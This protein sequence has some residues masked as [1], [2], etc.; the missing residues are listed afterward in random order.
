MHMVRRHR[1]F[2]ISYM[3]GRKRNIVA[4]YDRHILHVL[5]EVGKQGI[6]VNMLSKHVYNLSSTLFETPDYEEVYRYV[7]LFVRSHAKNS[8]SLL[9][10]TGEW[11]VYRLNEKSAEY[12]QAKLQFSEGEDAAEAMEHADDHRS[13]EDGPGHSIPGLFDE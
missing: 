8:H 2:S 3:R 11:G 7:Q 6:N 1:P 5:S 9:K 4:H 12:L 13:A 10:K